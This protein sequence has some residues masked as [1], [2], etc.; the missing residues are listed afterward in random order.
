MTEA[1]TTDSD[2]LVIG[3]G[4][5]FG[6]DDAAGL[7]VIRALEGRLPPGVRLIEHGGEGTGLVETWKDFRHVFIIDAVRSG[8]AA[9]TILRREGANEWPEARVASSHALGLSQALRLAQALGTMPPSLVVYGIE[10][11]RFDPGSTVS[12]EVA[13]GSTE[14]ADRLA[15]E[16][17][18][19]T[20]R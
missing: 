14:V 5:E 8:A 17:A 4:N 7:L 6:S 13:R 1:S 12:N 16:I 2:I 18:E 15:D 3:I 20:G 11:I 9:G 19:L 10:G